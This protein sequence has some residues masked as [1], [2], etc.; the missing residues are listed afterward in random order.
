MDHTV[1][2]CSTFLSVSDTGVSVAHHWNL[3]RDIQVWNIS[4]FLTVVCLLLYSFRRHLNVFTVKSMD[5][6]DSCHEALGKL[7]KKTC[8]FISPTKHFHIRNP[9]TVETSRFVKRPS[10]QS[11]PIQRMFVCF[12]S[13][14]CSGYNSVP[15]YQLEWR[16]VCS[17]AVWQV[18]P[19]VWLCCCWTVHY[20]QLYKFNQ[21]SAKLKE[22][23]VMEQQIHL[24]SCSVAG[25]G[26]YLPPTLWRAGQ[27]QEHI[28]WDRLP[29]M[30]HW[31]TQEMIPAC[32]S[33]YNSS[34]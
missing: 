10:S 26:L 17:C 21:M 4:Y 1:D 24:S 12:F 3:F 33:L 32:V 2:I 18:S 28:Q 8:G 14:Q 15:N 23:W 9:G 20:I 13:F 25:G 16:S 31:A 30:H 7:L 6:H 22:K 27:S 29:I 19:R 5:H 34:I 11:E